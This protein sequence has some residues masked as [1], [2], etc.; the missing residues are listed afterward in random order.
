MNFLAQRT[1]PVQ[2]KDKCY[3]QNQNLCY[4]IG[5]ENANKVPKG[6][7]SHK[8]IKIRSNENDKNSS[9]SK[10]IKYL[11]SGSLSSFSS[12]ST[13]SSS[14]SSGPT[15]MDAVSSLSVMSSSLKPKLTAR[16]EQYERSQ[17]NGEGENF[18]KYFDSQT[19]NNQKQV[20][21]YSHEEGQSEIFEDDRIAKLQEFR[22]RNSDECFTSCSKLSLHKFEQSGKS[23]EPG[24]GY[25]Y[26]LNRRGLLAHIGQ[27]PGDVQVPIV[28]S[29]S[30]IIDILR[31]K[32]NTTKEKDKFIRKALCRP[33]NSL[34]LKY[35]K[36]L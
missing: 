10:H 7:G 1:F 36:T 26:T 30:A 2:H 34:A 25:K 6:I 28:E 21:Y 3:C 18:N 12:V 32:L 20:G 9:S 29:K 8:F 17:T 22:I 19:W 31:Q 14:T 11:H 35:Q 33:E 4:C 27:I 16:R 15:A 24:P 13:M 5:I 23:K